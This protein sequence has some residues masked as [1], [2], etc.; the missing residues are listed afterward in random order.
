[1][2]AHINR[3]I[4]QRDFWMPFAP[5]VLGER[6]EDYVRVP[7]SLPKPRLSPHM[8]HAFDSTERR[9][10]LAAA[11]HSADQTAR[12]QTVW[13]DL[14]PS[15]YALIEAFG[16][17]TGRYV[18]LNTSFNLHGSPI[19]TGACDAVEV[20]LRSGL[21]YLVVDRWLIRKRARSS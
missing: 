4:K 9:A 14:N 17:K 12:M 16:R 7:T 3:M 13:K 21:E 20:L 18:L 11:V 19:V 6:A 15:F 1:M 8:M 5:A 10:D 2:V